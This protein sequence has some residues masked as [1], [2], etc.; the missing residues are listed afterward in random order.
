MLL[1]Y[2]A[3]SLT[4]D[5]LEPTPSATHFTNHRM[6]V[7]ECASRLACSASPADPILSL[8]TGWLRGG[9]GLR[10]K[11]SPEVAA[12]TPASHSVPEDSLRLEYHFPG[13]T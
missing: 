13:K 9:G 4:G 2:P 6:P 12:R 1:A 7:S 5:P 3:L 11:C 10:V 8:G